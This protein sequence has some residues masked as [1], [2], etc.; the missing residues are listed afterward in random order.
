MSVTDEQAL[1][2]QIVAKGLT[3][4]PRVTPEA[5]EAMIKTTELIKIEPSILLCVLTLHNGLTVVGKNLG[6]VCPENYDEDLAKQLAMRDA[7][8]QLW[9]LAGFMLAEDIHRGN[10]P[11]TQEQRELPDHVQRVL[12]EMYQVAARLMGLSE[13]LVQVDAGSLEALELSAVEVAD[14]R[15]QHG[16]MKDYVTVLQRRLSR[17]GV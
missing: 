14:L 5:L 16:L 9:P 11:L 1:E 13:F 3:K 12:T 15:E 4:A 10:R 2:Q 7:R 6:S 17:A 8:D